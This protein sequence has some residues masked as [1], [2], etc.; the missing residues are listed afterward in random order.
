V[1]LGDGGD[2]VV[3]DHD[4]IGVGIGAGGVEDGDVRHNLLGRR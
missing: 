3:V 4:V 2:A 1:G